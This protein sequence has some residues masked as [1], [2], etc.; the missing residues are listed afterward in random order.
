MTQIISLN[1]NDWLFKEYYG[2]DWLWRKSYLPDSSD[3]RWWRKASIPGSVVNDL[4]SLGE[5]N[6]P[7]FERNTLELEWVSQRTWLYKKQF[8]IPPELENKRVQLHFKGV[9]YEAKFYLNGVYLGSH[10]GMYTAA[11]FEI[12]RHLKYG[13]DNLIVVVIEAAPYEQ[14]QVGRT[15]H[16]YTHKSRMTYWWDFCPR[17]VHQGIWDDVYLEISGQVRVEDVFVRT[18]LATDHQSADLDIN[19]TLDSTTS[20]AVDMDLLIHSQ[21]KVV[22][23]ITKPI[24][25]EP[26]RNSFAYQ[27]LIHEPEVWQPNG[28][29]EQPLY[30]VEVAL[31]AEKSVPHS[32]HTKFGIRNIS[33]IANED[34]EQGALPYT[35]LV[36]GRIIYIKGWNWVPMDLLYGVPRHEKMNRLLRLAKEAHVNV[37]R[38][39][40]GG[41][42]EKDE[43]YDLC[44]QYGILIWQEFIQ[45]SS[46]IENEPSKEESYIRMLVEEAKEIIPR[47]RNHPALLLWCGGNELQ[48][49]DEQPLEDSH[50][51][52][53]ALKAVVRR[54][55]PD[56]L[57]LPT[58]PSGRIFG[59][60]LELIAKD[61]CALHD[62]HGP[63]EYQGAS[64]QYELYNRGTSL[65]HSEFGVEGIT[66]QRTL[67]AT[68]DPERQWPVSLDTN[69]CWWHLGAWWV[70]RKVWDDVFGE[71]PDVKTYIQA[72]QFTQFDGLRYALEA[73]R[74]RKY[75]NSGTLPWQFNEP[76]PMAACTSAV[77]YYARPKPVYY[78]VA[79]AYE[80]VHVSAKHTGL[81]W[82]TSGDFETEIWANNSDLS[83]VDDAVLTI[84]LM[85][86]SGK[87]HAEQKLTCPLPANRSACLTNF[88]A[89]LSD[90]E[91]VFFLDLDLRDNAGH[92]LS[93][94]RYIFVVGTNLQSLFQQKRTTIL[95]HCNQNGN[96]WELEV[97]NNG[98]QTAMFIWVEDDRSLKNTG[99]TYFSGNYFCLFPGE[100]RHLQVNWENVD[101]SERRLRL[102]A[103]NTEP[104]IIPGN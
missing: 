14:P 78:A 87:L 61:P 24:K 55:D 67:D 41:L 11:V 15:S 90:I 86:V 48:S 9:D 31:Q 83:A 53:A 64:Q 102:Q 70:R 96:E 66:N 19:I 72:T 89:P 63:W 95:C 18:R 74:R 12:E 62:V 98:T 49:G 13:S 103:W 73:D 68:I 42:I 26:G 21:E 99:Y 25:V 94:N 71:L 57:W 45:S 7:Y 28:Y 37:L 35:L 50:P 100:V 46:G 40:G 93:T 59:N 34:A 58:S 81:L 16:V 75:H 23:K 5:V 8:Y 10:R 6:N 29:G 85:S 69:P 56:R 43:F 65:L 97:L 47:K 39:W 51:T 91:P 79:K 4:W 76:Y 33:F 17:L 20:M 32:K 88:K 30:K 52:L 80:S 104:V 101:G 84:R 2:E 3:Q 44:D 1:G 22:S 36:N 60:S 38:V 54:L 27:Q 82:D 77:D 92:A